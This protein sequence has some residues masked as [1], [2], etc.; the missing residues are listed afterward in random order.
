MQYLLCHEASFLPHFSLRT[1]VLPYLHDLFPYS[2]S[3]P[4]DE[5]PRSRK[6]ITASSSL[7]VS[8]IYLSEIS[9]LHVTRMSTCTGTHF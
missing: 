9:A 7:R 6:K 5:F 4:G 2:A 8:E 1:T 3:L